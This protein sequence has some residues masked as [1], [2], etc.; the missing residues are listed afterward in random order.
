MRRILFAVAFAI[1][2]SGCADSLLA[3]KAWHVSPPNDLKW[4]ELFM[5]IP[6]VNVIE[7][8]H[9]MTEDQLKELVGGT[10]TTT[11]KMPGYPFFITQKDDGDLFEVAVKMTKDRKVDEVSFKK[12]EM[13][14][15]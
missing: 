10:I 8:K 12:I 11:I 7:I 13:P 15:K 5:Q 6:Y 9:G 2:L 4:S 3:T 14:N 1:Y